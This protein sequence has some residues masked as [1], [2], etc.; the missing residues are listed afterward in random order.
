LLPLLEL[1][2]VDLLP[3]SLVSCAALDYFLTSNELPSTPCHHLC[4]VV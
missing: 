4:P 1:P 2:L 3:F